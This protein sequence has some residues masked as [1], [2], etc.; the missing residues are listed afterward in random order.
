[1]PNY[2][3]SPSTAGTNGQTATTDSISVSSSSPIN[4]HATSTSTATAT[5]SS[6]PTSWPSTGISNVSTI[7]AKSTSTT[8]T[9]HTSIT[10]QTTGSYT[11]EAQ[12]TTV[13]ESS[14]VTP[15][16]SFVYGGSACTRTGYAVIG[17]IGL[18]LY[19]DNSRVSSI[20]AQGFCQSI[21][22]Q[23]GQ[24]VNSD[25]TNAATN[26]EGLTACAYGAGKTL[27][28]SVRVARQMCLYR[29]NY[30]LVG[31]ISK[32]YSY[33][34]AKLHSCQ[35]VVNSLYIFPAAW[36]GG[37]LSNNQYVWTV[38]KQAITS[39]WYNQKSPSS[40]YPYVAISSGGFFSTCL[41]GLTDTFSCTCTASV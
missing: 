1:L 41:Y 2:R 24:L 22:W 14:A 15:P 4:E 8:D 27:Y 3:T 38:S 11:T 35:N 23:L 21:G 30:Y 9:T 37:S 31:N 29:A 26:M 20:S 17:G 33:G 7:A 40:S 28:S 34:R 6:Q 32:L 25:L 5:S 39:G 18:A 12:T 16:T 13:A 36:V 10:A 19:M